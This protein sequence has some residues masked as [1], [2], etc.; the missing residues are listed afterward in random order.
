MSYGRSVSGPD[1]PYGWRKRGYSS[2][3]GRL[4]ATERACAI[5]ACS[6]GARV[7]SGALPW[8]WLRTLRS[9]WPRRY[10]GI[11]AVPPRNERT[12]SPICLGV[13]VSKVCNSVAWKGT[14]RTG[15]PCDSI[16]SASRSSTWLVSC[17]SVS[18]ALPKMRS[19]LS[20]FSNSD[21]PYWALAS[22]RKR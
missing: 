5:A 21:P 6:V 4:G 22:S 17:T 2:A 20:R 1:A 8:G 11:G 16:S 15:L 7:G 13:A 18:T 12:D 19:N 9:D 10:L 14:W 3:N